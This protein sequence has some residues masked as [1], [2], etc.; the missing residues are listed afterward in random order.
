MRGLLLSSPALSFR[1]SASQRALLAIAS[2][3]A[4]SLA[5]S[6]GLKVDLISH[7]AAVVAAYRADPLVHR[8]ATP[9]LVRFMQINAELAR[10][11]AGKLRIPVLV[12]VAGA[13]Q[14]VEPSGSKAFFDALA[15]GVGTLH[16]YHDAYHEIYN[17]SAERRTKVFA[18][19]SAWLSPRLV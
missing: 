4:P 16:W 3:I 8:V 13:D 2:R 6:N 12:Q 15:P 19:L 17:E 10:R 9:R 14:L 11:D 18:D 7:D 1:L 5:A